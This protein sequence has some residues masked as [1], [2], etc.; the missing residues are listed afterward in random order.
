MEATSMP[1]PVPF[2]EMKVDRP[3]FVT[4][5]DRQHRLPIFSGVVM[6]PEAK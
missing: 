2:A 3:F 6:N 1:A 4:V 5:I